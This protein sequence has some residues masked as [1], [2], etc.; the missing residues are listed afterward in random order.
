[1]IRNTSSDLLTS[2]RVASMVTTRDHASQ[3]RRLHS[4]I[5]L[6]RRPMSLSQWQVR[7]KYR[8]PSLIIERSIKT[9]T[10]MLLMKPTWRRKLETRSRSHRSR[11]IKEPL[12]QEN[13]MEIDSYLVEA[14][15]GDMSYSTS[16]KNT[17]WIVEYKLTP[18]MRKQMAL[19]KITRVPKVASMML[20]HSKE[21]LLIRPQPRFKGVKQVHKFQLNSRTTSM[22]TCFKH[23]V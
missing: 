18:Q 10:M 1:M 22:Q 2:A 4:G 20:N 16:M 7:K 14:T 6:T 23:S 9:R 21:T 19:V 13:S 17:S 11:L 12:L 3:I 8:S 15:M 5:A